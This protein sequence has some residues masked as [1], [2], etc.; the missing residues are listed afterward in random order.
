MPY[1]ILTEMSS[2]VEKWGDDRRGDHPSGDD[3]Q[4]GNRRESRCDDRRG[5]RRRPDEDRVSKPSGPL[6]PFCH[7]HHQAEAQCPLS[8]CPECLV[9]DHRHWNCPKKQCHGHGCYLYGHV[10]HCCPGNPKGEFYDPS[11]LPRVAAGEAPVVKIP[12]ALRIPVPSKFVPYWER[13][14]KAKGLPPRT[15]VPAPAPTANAWNV[16]KEPR[17][18]STPQTRGRVSVDDTIDYALNALD[19]LFGV[20][21][22]LDAESERLNAR[23]RQLQADLEQVQRELDRVES[24]RSERDIVAHIDQLRCKVKRNTGEDDV[25]APEPKRKNDAESEF[26]TLRE[27]VPT[28]PRTPERLAGIPLPPPIASPRGPDLRRHR[29]PPPHARSPAPTTAPIADNALFLQVLMKSRA[30]KAV[31]DDANPGICHHRPVPQWSRR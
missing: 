22:D 9:A 2:P 28:K 27:S 1:C 5:D 15:F 29:P 3:R 8:M 16:R 12:N 20:F 14:K 19:K 25:N 11:Y 7:H 6:C 24:F 21:S 30:A 26:P 17:L 10:A 13:E 4:G 31:K 18:P 23:K